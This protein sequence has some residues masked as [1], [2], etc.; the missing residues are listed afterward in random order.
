MVSAATHHL[1]V[2]LFTD[3]VG[4]SALKTRLGDLE[5]A[6]KI[7]R[8]HNAVFRRILASIPVAVEN[9]YTGDGFLATFANVGDAVN[10]ALRFQD[11]LRTHAWEAEAP[12][13][14]I[15]IHVGEIV[16]LE[17][18]DEG[19][20]LIASHAADMCARLMG[21]GR[22][23]Q[24]LL[25]RHAFDDGRQLV[26]AHPPL[27]EGGE[28]PPLQWLAH[29]RYRFK[30]KDDDPLEVF[31]VGATGF[32]PLL[33]PEDSEKARR[34]VDADEEE[35]LGWRPA[36]LQEVPS[37]RGWLLR[38]KLGVGGFG[39]VWLAQHAK[40][41][42]HRALKF[43]FDA[44]RLRSFRR[45]LTLFRL[46]REALGDRKD[47]ARLHE[48]QLDR[49]PYYLESEYT[50][51][52]DLVAWCEAHGGAAALPL[53]TRL[54]FVAGAAEA[55]GAAHSVGVLHKDLKPSNILVYVAE[56][57]TPR[58]RI[59][60]FG[61]GVLTDAAR[62]G[63]ITAAGF[64]LPN[65]TDNDSSRT[66]TRM[67]APPELLVGHPFTTR[68][69]VYALGV[70]LYQMVVGDL[71]RPLAAGWERDL[72]AALPDAGTRELVR[73][74]IAEMVDGDHERRL[75]SAAV[76]AERIRTLDARRAA[77]ERERQEA[78]QREAAERRAA[79]AE[80]RRRRTRRLAAAAVGV[81]LFLLAVGGIF[82]LRERTLR[83]DAEGARGREAAARTQAEAREREAK[84]A[85]AEADQRSRE[86]EQ[87]AGFQSEMLSRIDRQ[88]MGA[89]LREDL[90]AEAEA[91]LRRAGLDDAAAA[92]QLAAL[93]EALEGVNFT[94]VAVRSL[95]RNVLA[96]ALEAIDRK[97]GDQPLVQASLLLSVGATLESLGLLDAATGPLERA[98]KLRREILGDGHR[99][100][101][102]AMNQMGALLVRKGRD[103]DAEVLLRRALDRARAEF[104]R[105]DSTTLEILGN[106]GHALGRQGKLVEAETC[107]REDLESCQR[108][109]GE[110]HPDTFLALLGMANLL[111]EQG[112]AADA[113]RHARAALEGSR[114][115]LGP[116]HFT[117]LLALTAVAGTIRQ[118]ARYAEAE[119]FQLAS[120]EGH[121]R[122]L[123]DDHP[124][125][126]AAMSN[127]VA[128]YVEAG[129]WPD[130]EG[131]ARAALE[132]YRRTLGPD[133]RS[134][135]QALGN[136]GGLLLS[137]GR[138][139]EA[140]PI[141]REAYER[142]RRALGEDHPL[143]LE[144]AGN[145]GQA[146][147]RLGKLS[148]AERYARIDYEVST[149]A[150]GSDHPSALAATFN[151]ADLLRR[152]GKLAEAETH[153]RA[154]LAAYVR[155]RGPAHPSTL[156]VTNNLAFL[157]QGA[158]RDEEA[159]SLLR[160]A[161][162]ACRGASG[163]DSKGTRIATHC[164]GCFLHDRKRFDEAEPYCRA[165]L[166]LS[167]RQL[168]EDDPARV[169]AATYLFNCLTGLGKWE[170]VEPVARVLL[171]HYRRTLGDDD[172]GTVRM[173]S[174]LGGSL[175][176]QGRWEESLPHARTALEGYR[177]IHGPDHARTCELEIRHANALV[178]LRGFAEA[179]SL[180]L[181]AEK[182]TRENADAPADLPG[183]AARGLA[184]LYDAWNAAQPAQ[185]YDVK[186]AAW[187]EKAPPAA[188]K[189][190]G[191]GAAETKP[192]QPPRGS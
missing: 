85:R 22:P 83:E 20:L 80:A 122:A 86:L 68:G 16:L 178:H 169:G 137:Q 163:P 126:L 98:V 8:P 67:Y 119:S 161:L 103:A 2:L 74:D 94:N 76:V 192:P 182:A 101:L 29:G 135:V 138:L 61:I 172:A 184:D 89:R 162:D 149:R 9:N 96:R 190:A 144:A 27:A 154:A 130:A 99:E 7:A 106:L 177:R 32:A 125:T 168:P 165:A 24:I 12:R 34:V 87:V 62:L 13:T 171:E 18:R 46:L 59:T 142:S 23:G 65:L 57:G 186:G 120:L 47:I 107:H 159:E 187:R 128:L 175:R 43:C 127:L 121:Q 109:H 134:A 88:L 152:Q 145:L 90:R 110:E 45:E 151:L 112:K 21:L 139:E 118:Q 33:S 53:A 185:G 174:Y 6:E 81:L 42:E 181:H 170:E 189:E 164:L 55:V 17:G 116:D 114:R 73:T 78:Q 179:E 183:E 133:H 100:T 148:D 37:R 82:L 11:A 15:G 51:D 108:V 3:L 115:L 75:S 38:R 141:F 40:T 60:D 72:D 129:R 150:W 92:A 91:A 84:L 93:D 105:D 36:T 69:D 104:G 97:F 188:P 140:E 4:S 30:G 95:D 66:G 25:T 102:R 143:T 153:Y 5:Y 124:E 155:V 64:T 113:E 117:T 158:K 166:E 52:G 132:G 191:K 56:D 71:N 111:L 1:S 35:L 44:D 14:R 147:V 31:E 136:L 41:G 156:S 63:N 146:L 77:R 167:Q 131:H 19:S 123:G 26:R 50:P 70:L 173:T 54:D 157:L 28:P 48:V 176:A 10:A 180:L 49:P 39:E 160:Q 79:E 58:A